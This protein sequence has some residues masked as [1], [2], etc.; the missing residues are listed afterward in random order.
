M[1]NRYITITIGI[2]VTVIFVLLAIDS[3]TNYGMT[4]GAPIYLAFVGVG[5]LITFI[6]ILPYILEYLS[7]MFD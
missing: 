1:K 6:G 3:I 5:A 2:I 7:D 4:G